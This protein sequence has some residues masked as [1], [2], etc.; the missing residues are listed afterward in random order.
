MEESS[1]SQFVTLEFVK[2]DEFSEEGQ[3]QAETGG[4][5]QNS[6]ELIEH[7][8]SIHT[9][10]PSSVQ[11]ENSP[12]RQ[13][14]EG[15]AAQG[16]QLLLSPAEAVTNGTAVTATALDA[17]VGTGQ[18]GVEE[19]TNAKKRKKGSPRTDWW[20]D[21][22]AEEIIKSVRETSSFAL[23]IRV[24]RKQDEEGYCTLEE[25]TIRKWFQKGS[26]TELTPKAE[27][28]LKA[29]TSKSCSKERKPGVAGN[30]VMVLHPE[31]RVGIKRVLQAIKDAGH[32]L[33]LPVVEG[34]SN[35]MITTLLPTL[36]S[37]SGASLTVRRT[38]AKQ[39]VADE[40]AI[41]EHQS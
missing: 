2:E 29:K 1:A 13:L 35:A 38:F 18:E 5:V 40:F 11:V 10:L 31:I 8:E 37:N 33:D 9:I 24:L 17:T 16:P 30:E 28:Y 6:S 20:K 36:L 34:V 41:T 12:R 7:Q 21:G 3:P 4:D 26:Y 19:G 39:F 23:T 27:E 22:R 25:S 15:A 32:E 14:A